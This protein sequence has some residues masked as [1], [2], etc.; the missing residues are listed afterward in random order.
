MDIKTKIK[1]LTCWTEDLNEYLKVPK[2]LEKKVSKDDITN[3]LR[4]VAYWASSEYNASNIMPSHIDGYRRM[5]EKELREKQ[6]HTWQ[7]WQ[8]KLLWSVVPAAISY[9]L[10][11]LTALLI[12]Y[13]EANF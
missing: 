12:V 13:I 7:T 4:E 6:Q 10:G 11:I 9:L 3:L 8:H 5:L 1:V 2:G